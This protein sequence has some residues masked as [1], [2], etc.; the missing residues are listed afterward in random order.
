M[1]TKLFLET[2]TK[3]GPTAGRQL[4]VWPEGLWNGPEL[5]DMFDFSVSFVLQIRR[6]NK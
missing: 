5:S 2:H 4:A 1:V 3:V 6:P